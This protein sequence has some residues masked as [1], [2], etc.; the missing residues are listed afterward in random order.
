[1]RAKK[2]SAGQG[3]IFVNGRSQAVRLPQ[4]FRL[5]GTRVRVSRVD[6]G[7]LLTPIFDDVDAWFAEMDRL[8]GANFFEEGREQPDMPSRSGIFE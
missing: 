3:T 6:N 7:V 5:P 1:M 4:E 2:K 8:D